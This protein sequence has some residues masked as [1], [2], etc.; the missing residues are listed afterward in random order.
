MRAIIR[1]GRKRKAEE[2]SQAPTYRLRKRTVPPQRI[3]R[4]MK[5]HRITDETTISEAGI[6]IAMQLSLLQM[7]T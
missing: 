4:Y 5:D 6:L 1:K 3:E 2:P 7:V